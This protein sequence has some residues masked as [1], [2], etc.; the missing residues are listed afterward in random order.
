MTAHSLKILAILLFIIALVA[1]TG[2]PGNGVTWAVL[3]V[4]ALL[5]DIATKSTKET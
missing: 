4:G 2:G 1:E 3:G 5:A